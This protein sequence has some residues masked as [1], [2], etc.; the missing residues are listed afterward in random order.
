MRSS[1]WSS[2]VCS[3]ELISF[4]LNAA[5]DLPTPTDVRNDR[6]SKRGTSRNLWTCLAFAGFCCAFRGADF[7]STIGTP[8]DPLLQTTR[9]QAPPGEI[10]RT[11]RRDRVCPY[12]WISLGDETNK[13]KT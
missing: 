6:A 2:D 5:V 9:F 7:F 12:G 10:G 8:G 11:S 13:K 3:S 4:G 1:D